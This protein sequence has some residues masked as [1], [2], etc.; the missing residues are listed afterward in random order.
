[1]KEKISCHT[2]IMLSIPYDHVITRLP[3]PSDILILVVCHTLCI[4]SLVDIFIDH[5][6]IKW[7]CLVNPKVP[8][9]IPHFEW[10][11]SKRWTKGYPSKWHTKSYKQVFAVIFN[12]SEEK[13]QSCTFDPDSSISIV[14]NSDNIHICKY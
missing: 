4:M 14:D 5:I 1:M 2:H 12:V 10:K 13:I 7:K 6:C 11:S 3:R 9:S 8:E